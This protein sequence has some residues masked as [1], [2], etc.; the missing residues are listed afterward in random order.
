VSSSSSSSQPAPPSNWPGE[1]L[2]FPR[3][4][5]GSVARSG[6]RLVAILIDFALCYVVY[7]AFFFG[8]DWA[9]LAIFATEQIVLLT[10]L[11]SGVGHA[12]MGIRLVRL[13]GSY[14]GV[15][16]PI[17]RTALLLLLIPAVVWDSDQRG[18]HDVIAGT[19]LVRRR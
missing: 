10:T 4:G 19:V 5:V 12:I 11:G 17:V 15:W 13:D 7:Y 9:S 18:L 6:R 16:R 3:S 1:R 2:G 14:A 8:N